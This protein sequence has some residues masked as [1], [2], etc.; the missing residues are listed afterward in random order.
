MNFDEYWEKAEIFDC[1]INSAE[2]VWDKAQE[3]CAKRVIELIRKSNTRMQFSHLKINPITY[4][5][6]EIKKEFIE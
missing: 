5:E 6:F 3:E 1:G 2:E 4:L